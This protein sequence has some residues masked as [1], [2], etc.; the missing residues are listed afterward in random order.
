MT[1]MTVTIAES[2]ESATNFPEIMDF[3]EDVDLNDAETFVAFRNQLRD[4]L[5]S[6]KLMGSPEDTTISLSFSGGGDSGNWDQ[7]HE[8][9]FVMNL[10]QHLLDH[11]VNFDWYNNEGGGGTIEWDLTTDTITIDGYYNETVQTPVGSAV[12]ESG[13]F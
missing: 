10:F 8:D 4:R 13:E 11:K 7:E 5:L 12:L 6:E 2:A 3:S 9:L 1:A